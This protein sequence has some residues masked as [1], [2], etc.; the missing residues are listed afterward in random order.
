MTTPVSPNCVNAALNH[1]RN[2]GRLVVAT[3]LR[4]III[5]RKTLLRFEKGGHWLLKAEGDGF[6]LR[7]GQG[8]V[9]LLP[10][11]LCMTE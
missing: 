4:V 7:S 5:D 1:V 2:G 8:S 11:Q 3:P 9:Y 6:R 10:G